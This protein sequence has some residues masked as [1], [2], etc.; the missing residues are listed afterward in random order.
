[1]VLIGGGG[2]EGRLIRRDYIGVSDTGGRVGI[3][4]NPFFHFFKSF[5][6]HYTHLQSNDLGEIPQKHAGKHW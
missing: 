4:L 6:L 5:L 2:D 3:K 1:M